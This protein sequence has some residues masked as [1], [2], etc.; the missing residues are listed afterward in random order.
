MFCE[1]FLWASPRTGC[2][3]RKDKFSLH[4][5]VLQPGTRKKTAGT[6]YHSH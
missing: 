5:K 4:T 1:K 2:W 6:K 3:F